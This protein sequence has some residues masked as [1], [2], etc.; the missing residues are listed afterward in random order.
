[1]E[2][3]E[4]KEIYDKVYNLYTRYPLSTEMST[5]AT[6]NWM[7]VSNWWLVVSNLNNTVME[8]SDLLYEII[9]ALHTISSEPS[10]IKF[11]D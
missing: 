3:K 6:V 7:I 8:P 5:I 4:I 11:E 1:M 10:S 9:S 2:K